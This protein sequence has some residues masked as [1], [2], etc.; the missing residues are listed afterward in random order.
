[1]SDLNLHNFCL[2]IIVA[3]IINSIVNIAFA[4]D[5]V[6]VVTESWYPYNY[7][8]KN[9]NVVGQSTETI[10]AILADAGVEYS[11]KLYPWARALNHASKRTNTLIY[12]ILRTPKREKLYHWFCPISAIQ[13]HKIYKLASRKDITVDSEQEIKKYSISVTRNTFLHQ[14]M[15]DIGLVDGVNLQ[16]N[17]NDAIDTKMFFA[18]RVDLLA[19]LE[20]SM[21]RTLATQGWDKSI[22]TPLTTIPLE[23]YSPIC[24][25]LSKKTPINLVN[26]IAHAHQK[27]IYKQ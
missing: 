9:G 27:F 22:V 1:L 4:N 8:D 14:Y 23:H 20:S 26:K 17:S 16:I 15:L 24:M 21:E 19:D 10:K 2:V 5:K 18:G 3:V 12:S 6:Q 7:L 11:I 13:P 25:A